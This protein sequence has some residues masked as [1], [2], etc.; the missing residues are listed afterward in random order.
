MPWLTEDFSRQDC[1]GHASFDNTLSDPS[2]LWAQ[3]IS[4]RGNNETTSWRNK[5]K[6]PRPL[7]ALTDTVKFRITAD[8]EHQKRQDMRDKQARTH[9]ASGPGKKISPFDWDAQMPGNHYRARRPVWTEGSIRMRK[10]GSVP[11]G[12]VSYIPPDVAKRLAKKHYKKPIDTTGVEPI[13]WCG[14]GCVHHDPYESAK[15]TILTTEQGW[16]LRHTTSGI[17]DRDKLYDKWPQC[18]NI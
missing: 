15:K 10:G 13:C 7:T 1:R 3:L 14:H 2:R 5:P 6:S 8:P 16:R 9:R 18:I 11:Q 17:R 4:Q 12:M